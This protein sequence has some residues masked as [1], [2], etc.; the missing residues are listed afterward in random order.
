MIGI[1]GHVPE[2]PQSL[3]P[4][5]SRLGDLVQTSRF[6]RVPLRVGNPVIPIEHKELRVCLD[7]THPKLLYFSY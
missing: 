5:D 6:G 2:I 7:V 1:P 4:F 3:C